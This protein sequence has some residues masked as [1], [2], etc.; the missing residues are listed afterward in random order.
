MVGVDIVMPPSF[1]LIRLDQTPGWTSTSSQGTLHFTGGNAPQGTYVQFTFAGTFAKK[2]VLLLPVTTHAADRT[3]RQ[4]AGQPSDPFPAA[5]LFPGYPRGQAPIP[6]VTSSASG[7]KLLT[8][9]GRVLVVAGAVALIVLAVVRRQAAKKRAARVAGR[10]TA[11]PAG[12]TAGK[13]SRP[14]EGGAGHRSVT[15]GPAPARAPGAQATSAPATKA[16]GPARAKEP[17]APDAKAAGRSRRIPR[18]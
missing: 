8:W 12:K 6:G 3:E 17:G 2:A 5:L 7:T 11:R 9:A 14:G 1:H 13:T 18:P 16:A 4:W 15:G 10:R